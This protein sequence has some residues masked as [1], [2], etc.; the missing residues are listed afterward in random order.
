MSDFLKDK[1]ALVTGGA[2]G[3][4]RAI[5]T[6]FAENGADIVVADVQ[7]KPREG[8]RPTDE[9]IAAETDAAARFVSCDVTEFADL[10]A[11]VDAAEEF[12]GID[13]MVNN[14]GILETGS[15]T[16]LSEEAFDRLMAV[17]VK[18]VFLGCKAVAERMRDGTGGSI[19]NISSNAGIRGRANNS[20][21][22]ASKGAVRLM[23]YALAD[24]LGPAIRVNAI[25]PGTTETEMVRED[26]EIVGTEEARKRTEHIPLSRLGKPAD[27]AEAAL[28]LASG[29][30]SYVTA[31]S[32]V[33]DGGLSNT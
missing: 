32:L 3:N 7:R 31:S 24:E 4:G 16:E 10:T 1:V 28:Y 25:H 12:G 27:V 22:C 21:Y 30:S 5:A 6:K 14:A 8:G 18:G 9:R 33:V 2:S 13:V 20:A 26:I 29:L 17:N 15:V 19:V 11:A 23:T